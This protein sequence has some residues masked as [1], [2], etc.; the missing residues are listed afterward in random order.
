MTDSKS[1]TFFGL[2][3]FEFWNTGGN[4]TAFGRRIDDTKDD[5]PYVLVTVAE[6]YDG[7]WMPEAMH[8]TDDDT[9]LAVS[10]FDDDN[11]DTWVVVHSWD[12]AIKAANDLIAKHPPP[13]PCDVCGETKHDGLNQRTDVPLQSAPDR[14]AMLCDECNEAI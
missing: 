14:A 9:D 5:S 4:C 7:D 12:D 11:D 1:L 10:Y 6:N 3:G 2:A 13:V 8:P